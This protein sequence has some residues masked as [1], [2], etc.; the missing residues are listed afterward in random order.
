M[1][2]STCCS[3]QDTKKYCWKRCGPNR[4]SLRLQ[5]GVA[6]NAAVAFV[7]NIGGPV[8]DLTALGDPINV[9]AR[10][11]QR[12]AAGELVVARECRQPDGTCAAHAEFART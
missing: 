1:M 11:R 6:V 5:R 3:E 9:V 8:V 7:G 2:C 10:M 12:G 4:C